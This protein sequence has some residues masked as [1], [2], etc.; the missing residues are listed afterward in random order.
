MATVDGEIL[1]QNL[2]M[3]NDLFI[4]EPELTLPMFTI[5]VDVN[6]QFDALVAVPSIS[7]IEVETGIG[8]GISAELS[9]P[10][11]AGIDAEI[12]VHNLVE[13]VITLPSLLSIEMEVGQACTID[14]EFTLPH[15]ELDAD[16][17]VALAELFETWVI[18]AVTFAHA[19]YDNY[20]FNSY[21]ELNGVYCG[22]NST[23][24]HALTG[25]TDNGTAISASATWGKVNLGTDMQKL[26]DGGY[27]HCRMSD[28]LVVGLVADGGTRYPYVATDSGMPDIHAERWKS[29]KGVKGVFYQPDVA[30]VYGAD[31]DI[32]QLDLNVVPLSRRVR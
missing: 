26:I 1:L 6:N 32:S 27:L 8:V 12:F 11:I 14:A 17:H 19:Q 10:S 31:F 22:L 29:C 16:V 7:G 4:L 21:V 25:N 13:G 20:S 23:G 2:T 9:L 15:V 5:E 28:A 3:D 18:N 24:I 30:N